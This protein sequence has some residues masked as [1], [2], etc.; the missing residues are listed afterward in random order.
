MLYI[1][2]ILGGIIAFI[3][4]GFLLK[5][6]HVFGRIRSV[7]SPKATAE[8]TRRRATSHEFSFA[9]PI[10]MGIATGIAFVVSYYVVLLLFS[11]TS[12]LPYDI[13]MPLAILVIILSAV[14]VLGSLFGP[15]VYVGKKF[16]AAEGILTF[17]I[18]VGVAVG[19]LVMVGLFFNV[20]YGPYY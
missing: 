16:G 9:R 5:I 6:F 13:Q 19:I 3:V 1:W 14:L 7:L 17:F 12:R 20:G 8:T 11:L 2:E 15:A 10:T 4:F 18:G